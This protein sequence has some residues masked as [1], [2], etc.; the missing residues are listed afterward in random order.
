MDQ[1]TQIFQRVEKK[2][3]LTEYQYFALRRFLQGFARVDRY[4][5]TGILN[6][7]YDTPDFRLIRESIDGPAYKEKLRLR[8]YGVPTDDSDAFIE[9][10]KKYKG[11]VY[12]R[13]IDMPY[14][15]AADY[16]DRTGTQNATA[17][18]GSSPADGAAGE[19]ISAAAAGIPSVAAE[20]AAGI[21][22]ETAESAAEKTSTDIQIRREIEWFFQIYPEL[23]PRMAISY[24]RIAM[25]GI[26]DPDFRVT[27]DRNI[28]WR[29]EDLDLEAGNGGREILNPGTYLMELKIRGA[30]D[31]ALAYEMSRLGIFPIGFSKYGQGFLAMQKEQ[32]KALRKHAGM[33]RIPAAVPAF[34]QPSASAAV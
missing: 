5:E 32:M 4:G 34:L 30:A 19:K 18:V 6:I 2:Y 7:Y 12:K 27:F 15:Q 11:I 17:Q 24:D 29:T 16:L 21:P 23:G 31:P 26:T 13:R 9:I 1:F 8:S 25:E 14:R 10:K 3:L 28:R 33:Y 22:S 20:N